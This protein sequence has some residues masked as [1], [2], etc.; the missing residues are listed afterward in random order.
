MLQ[1]ETNRNLPTTLELL[2][3]VLAV[4]GVL[5]TWL[6]VSS[7]GEI[8]RLTVAGLYLAVVSAALLV[9]GR[10]ARDRWTRP[11]RLLV[12]I[13]L[14]ATAAVTGLAVALCGFGVLLLAACQG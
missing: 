13:A 3:A 1:P 8:S 5:V 12:S 14:L 10:D 4:T 2:A 11:L 9:V 6:A 7:V